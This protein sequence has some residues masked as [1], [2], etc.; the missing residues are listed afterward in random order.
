MTNS[1]WTVEFFEDE[2]GSV[3]ERWLDGLPVGAR[4]AAIAAIEAFLER[5]GPD[6]CRTENGKALGRGLYELRIRHDA[7]TIIAKAGLPSPE[8]IPGGG[9]RPPLLRIFFHAYGERR[10]ILLGGYDKRADSSPRRQNREVEAAR[11]RLR[12]FKLRIQ[13]DAGAGRGRSRKGEH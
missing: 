4:W 12:S 8:T 2:S 1:A 11:S 10:I 6:V 5:F 7:A 13:R 9:E 3:V